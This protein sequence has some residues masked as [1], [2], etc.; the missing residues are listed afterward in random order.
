MAVL[1]HLREQGLTVSANSGRLIVGPRAALTV[2]IRTT[3]R[4]NKGAILR[5]LSAE[6]RGR[7]MAIVSAREASCIADFRHALVFGG[8]VVCGNC[9]RFTFGTDPAGDG[10]CSTFNENAA[11][12]VPFT[13]SEFEL[14]PTPTAPACLPGGDGNQIRLGDRS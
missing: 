14:S 1:T 11:P 5:D 7:A 2:A 10:Q 3:I 6:A 12:F 8:F 4:I 9:S 13:C